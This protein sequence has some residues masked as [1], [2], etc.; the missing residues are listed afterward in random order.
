V[1]ISADRR[2]FEEEFLTVLNGGDFVA[3]RIPEP[4][5]TVRYADGGCTYEGRTEFDLS[6]DTDAPIFVELLND[7][8]EQVAV[9]AGAHDGVSWEQ[10]EAD[11]VVYEETLTPPEYWVPVAT[12]GIAGRS[13]TGGTTVGELDLE[14]GTYAIACGTAANDVILLTDIV[15]SP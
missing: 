1:A 4:D 5:F 7:S 14:P 13:V 11:A 9:T 6:D 10:L 8:D 2:G 15:V 3:A 12:I